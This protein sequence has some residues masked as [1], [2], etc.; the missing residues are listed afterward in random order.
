MPKIAISDEIAGQA[1]NDDSGVGADLVSV[2]NMRDAQGRVPYRRY[3]ALRIVVG[4]RQ[5]VAVRG[6]PP[7]AIN[8]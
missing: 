6:R 7:K 8:L 3:I 4:A 1:R 2:R 5:S